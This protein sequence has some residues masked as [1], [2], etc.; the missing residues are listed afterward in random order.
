[1]RGRH[2]R[3]GHRKSRL[4]WP[5]ETQGKTGGAVEQNPSYGQG[6][7]AA[8]RRHRNHPHGELSQNQHETRLL[9]PLLLRL[10]NPSFAEGNW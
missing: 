3:N 5:E 10:S 7:A 4:G 8:S 9:V 6:E 1:M 2:S